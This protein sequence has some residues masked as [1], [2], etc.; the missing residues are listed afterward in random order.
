[1]VFH[2]EGPVRRTLSEDEVLRANAHRDALLRER[3]HYAQ[4][5][6]SDRVKEVDA[7]LK[8]YGFTRATLHKDTQE[9]AVMEKGTETR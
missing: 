8:V 7:E 5:G 9:R 3:S 1:M 4:R 2:D 6:E